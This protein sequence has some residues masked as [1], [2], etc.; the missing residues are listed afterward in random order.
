MTDPE[1]NRVFDRWVAIEM[2]TCGEL[3]HRESLF[4]AN[5][6]PGPVD[7]PSEMAGNIS[8]RL[9]LQLTPTRK[10]RNPQITQKVVRGTQDD[11]G[12]AGKCE[13]KA[14]GQGEK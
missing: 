9:P 6:V 5:S 2:R 10:C 12:T 8:I 13:K 11:T 1:I 4:T 7:R 14:E 3:V